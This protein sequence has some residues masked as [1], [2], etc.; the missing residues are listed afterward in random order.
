[1]VN[2]DLNT[3]SVIDL[4]GTYS[5]SLEA[6]STETGQ[7][8]VRNDVTVGGEISARGGVTANTGNFSG[9]LAVAGPVN[10][11][12]L[13]G[14][15]TNVVTIDASGNLGTATNNGSY[16]N[17]STSQQASANFNIDGT[18][19]A[20]HFNSANDYQIGGSTVLATDDISL[21][22]GI[23]AG[24]TGSGNYNTSVGTNALANSSGGNDVAMG[25][26]AMASNTSGIQNTALGTEALQLNSTGS[27]NTAVG[28]GAMADNGTGSNNVAVGFYAM[29]SN[30][31]N[32]LT[33][34]NNTAL[35][36]NS[37]YNQISSSADN[38]GV[39]YNT[40][41]SVT[42]GTQ[43]TVIGSGADVNSGTATN[44]TAIGYG[45]IA[46][47]DNTIQ[48]GSTSVTAVITSGTI[49]AGGLAVGGG[50]SYNYRAVTGSP[51]TANATDYIVN[52]TSGTGVTLPTGG[53]GQ[54]ILVMNSTGATLSSGTST[55]H[56]PA[57]DT[58]TMLWTGSSWVHM[59]IN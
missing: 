20:A 55:A 1:V 29:H 34:N 43:N 54:V 21:A 10:M 35:G 5:Q 3:L 11:S 15:G 13:T 42:T 50:V 19:T 6:G 16:I 47:S 7:L 27:G 45:A 26:Y 31:P 23:G 51:A 40:L 14:S 18:G 59:V 49:T 48:L 33:G 2:I 8:Q 39:G 52:I 17:N 24:G 37:L 12:G 57:G 9:G 25:Y 22:V 28:S 41:L 53:T 44:R 46:T 36:T 38:T 58:W 4:G 56:V 32:Q 30:Y